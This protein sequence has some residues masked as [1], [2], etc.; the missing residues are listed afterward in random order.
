MF[1]NEKI[2][3]EVVQKVNEVPKSKVAWHFG[4]D[5][6][7]GTNIDFAKKM[8][9]CNFPAAVEHLA[10]AFNITAA[11]TYKSSYNV[12]ITEFELKKER[13]KDMVDRYIPKT[14]VKEEPKKEEVKVRYTYRNIPKSLLEELAWEGFNVFPKENK[15]EIFNEKVQVW[16]SKYIDDSIW[17]MQTDQLIKYLKDLFEIKNKKVEE[18]PLAWL[19]RRIADSKKKK[20][21]EKKPGLME[22]PTLPSESQLIKI[23]YK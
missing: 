3:F 16:E 2:P 12:F 19:D 13:L 23:L 14:V 20:Q 9:N 6:F 5:D 15:I 11:P 7:T 4:I 17:D 22:Q 18:D 21:V 1:S 8:L 10:K